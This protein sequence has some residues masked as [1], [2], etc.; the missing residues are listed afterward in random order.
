MRRA[1]RSQPVTQLGITLEPEEYPFDV[2]VRAPDPDGNHVSIR[3][4]RK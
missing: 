1:L 4:R 3:H 2:R